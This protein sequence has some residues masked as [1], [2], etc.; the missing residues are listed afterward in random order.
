MFV[1][2]S[3][4]HEKNETPYSARLKTNKEIEE[5]KNEEREK[6]IFEEQDE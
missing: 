4:K 3:L 1:Q 6:E 5:Q 2:P